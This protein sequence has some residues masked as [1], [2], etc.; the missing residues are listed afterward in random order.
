MA[1]R[2]IQQLE[3]TTPTVV[4]L[5]RDSV[6][7]LLTSGRHKD[8][9]CV[10]IF[11]FAALRMCTHSPIYITS[12]TPRGVQHKQHERLLFVYSSQDVAAWGLQTAATLIVTARFEQND[13]CP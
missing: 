6:F 3:A 13:L 8:S 5:T 4:S 11:L 12:S 1:T 7:L 9:S 10:F 2:T